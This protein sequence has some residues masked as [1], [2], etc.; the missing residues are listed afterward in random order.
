MKNESRLGSVALGR[1][2]LLAALLLVAA[3]GN[4][5]QKN[6]ATDT[7][8]SALMSEDKNG[9]DA[10]A[11]A[12]QRFARAVGDSA[13][14]VSR[15]PY[16]SDDRNRAAGMMNWARMIIR[17][18]EEDVVQD[19]DFPYFRVVDFRTREGGDNA[20]QRYLVTP[21]RGGATY[22]VWGRR[23]TNR[24]LDFQLYDGLPWLPSGGRIAAA[25]PSEKLEVNA[26][27]SFEVFLGG[28][29][30]G[31]NWLDN[32]NG[33][34]TLMVRQIFSDWNRELPDDIHIDRIDTV[35]ARK[36]AMSGAELIERFDRA[37]HSLN[38]IVPLWPEF[39]RRFYD[40][41]IPVN[42][43]TP[44]LDPSA[45]GGVKERWMAF[46]HFDLAD[47]E[48]LVITTWPTGADYQGI[49]LTDM[50]FASLEYANAQSS[51]SADQAQL[52]SDGAFHFVIAGSDPG[53]RNW[54]DTQR[55]RQ[56]VILLRYDGMRGKEIPR[57]RWPRARKVKLSE[58]RESLPADTP[59]YDAAQRARDLEQRRKHVQ[60]RFGV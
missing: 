6:A 51:L 29:R 44:P 45:G 17:T 49:Q 35:G 39:V 9:D 43:L 58:L 38:V 41:G 59:A 5:E 33:S 7:G 19:V 42:T 1:R 57:E 40:E 22:R 55:F 50:W 12:A 10:L 13:Q 34:T 3:A 48:A 52:G 36:P 18:L 56:G 60:Q 32:P 4:A 8:G 20:D 24:R 31:A 37:A 16:Y 46:G 53:V 47:D 27:G 26:D 15:H 54:L 2:L 30:R 28:E 25:L 23:G 14:F 11:A 21:L